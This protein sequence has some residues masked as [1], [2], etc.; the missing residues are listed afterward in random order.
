M[1]SRL[2]VWSINRPE[3]FGAL[4]AGLKSHVYNSLSPN[5]SSPLTRPATR[6]LLK[7]ANAAPRTKV[8]VTC[9]ATGSIVKFL[10][11]ALV[12]WLESRGGLSC[13]TT[14]GSQHKDRLSSTVAEALEGKDIAF[15]ST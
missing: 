6:A 9:S 10:L 12:P 3:R 7:E 8:C 1:L 2:C 13:G 5:I 15:L 11:L 14:E 4:V